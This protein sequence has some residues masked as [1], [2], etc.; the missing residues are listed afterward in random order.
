[1]E[2]ADYH[3]SVA[4]YYDQEASTFENRAETNPVLVELRQQFREVVL[5]GEVD[6]ILEIGYGPG[7]DM[8]WFAER[9]ETSLVQGLDITPNFHKI[10]QSK[11]KTNS[12]LNPMLGG[13]EDILDHVSAH[14]IDTIYIFFG[15][16]NTCNDIQLAVNKMQQALRPGGRIVATFVNKWYAFDIFWNLATFRPKKALARMR[17]VWGGYSPTRFLPSRC[18]SARQIHKI[19]NQQLS[20]EFR[21]GFCITHPAWYRQHWAP[22]GSIRS[23]LLFKID[24]I[25]QWTPFWNCG[26]YSLYVYQNSE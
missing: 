25:L 7:L 6:T 14:S 15:A 24:N 2:S 13:P 1:M 16:L 3:Q 4:D 22:V 5:Q 18:Y 19:F 12:K 20:R 17:K 9:E 8:I 10:V 11:C 26:E 23:K 21:K